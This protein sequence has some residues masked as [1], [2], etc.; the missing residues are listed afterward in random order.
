MYVA[1][2]KLTI[3]NYHLHIIYIYTEIC[4]PISVFYYLCKC[5]S[6]S[7]VYILNPTLSTLCSV[8]LHNNRFNTKQMYI[9]YKSI[10]K[11]YTYLMIFF[12]YDPPLCPSIGLSV[13]WLVGLSVILLKGREVTLP[14]SLKKITRRYKCMY[15]H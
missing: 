5:F 13:G 11:K 10:Y 7:G 8:N 2:P 9:K 12:P 6:P 4:K 14:C 3:I 1:Q 15:S